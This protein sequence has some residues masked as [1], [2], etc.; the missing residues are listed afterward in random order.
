MLSDSVATR[1]G[2][3]A[4]K[5]DSLKQ[6]PLHRAAHAGAVDC[7]LALLELGHMVAAEQTQILYDDRHIHNQIIHNH[8]THTYVIY[9][10]TLYYIVI[11]LYYIML[12]YVIL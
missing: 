3:D 2:A 7:I 9:I 1:S 6:T 8:N 12:Y 4:D 11:I 10:Y 5:R